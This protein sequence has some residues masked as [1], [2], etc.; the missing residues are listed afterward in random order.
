METGHLI[1]FAIGLG[2][3]AFLIWMLFPIAVRSPVEEKPRGFCPLCAHPLMKGERVRSDQTEIGDIEVQTRIKGCQFCMGPTAKRKR[4]CPVC[5]K[6]V[7]KDEVILALAD[8]R[9]DRLKLKIK[10]CKACWPQGF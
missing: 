5:K 1:L 6:D 8:P 9:V 7:K 10:G 3:I 4:S 2:L